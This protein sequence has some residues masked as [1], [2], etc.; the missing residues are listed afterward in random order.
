MGGAG[1]KCCGGASTPGKDPA[2]KYLDDIEYK[3][4][5]SSRSLPAHTPCTATIQFSCCEV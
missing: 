5:G 3:V 4:R 2:D 1:S